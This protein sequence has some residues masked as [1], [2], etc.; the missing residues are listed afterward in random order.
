MR[1]RIFLRKS[2]LS[3]NRRT[4]KKYDQDAWAPEGSELSALVLEG[5]E[6]S[7]LIPEGSELSA[8][9]AQGSKEAP[10]RAPLR[11]VRENV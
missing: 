2:S 11:R 9:V 7:A 5:P 8:V 6:L 4:A 1:I 10:N 3:E